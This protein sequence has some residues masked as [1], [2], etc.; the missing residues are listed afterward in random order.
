VVFIRVVHQSGIHAPRLQRTEELEG[1]THGH[2]QVSLTMDDQG[3]GLKVTCVVVRRDLLVDLRA[4]P[5]LTEALA[6]DREVRGHLRVQVV[7]RFRLRGNVHQLRHARL[8]AVGH[9]VLRDARRNLRVAE[10][11][12][13]LLVE[14]RHDIEHAPPNAPVDARRIGQVEH[15]GWVGIGPPGVQ[16]Q[17]AKKGDGLLGG[18]AREMGDE[19]ACVLHSIGRQIAILA[20][21]L[22]RDEQFEARIRADG[23]ALLGADAGSYQQPKANAY[24]VKADSPQ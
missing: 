3:R 9:L 8:H 17:A 19:V 11:F 5:E 16:A 15:G 13:A 14:R 24:T 1:L 7:D 21:E 4:V 12:A 10:L 22:D 23:Q 20:E 18:I 2:A 6:V